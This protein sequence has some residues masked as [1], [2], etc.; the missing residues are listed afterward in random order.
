MIVLKFE[1]PVQSPLYMTHNLDYSIEYEYNQM[2]RRNSENKLNNRF[3]VMI[4]LGDIVLPKQQTVW[5]DELIERLA[6][7]GVLER[8][9]RSTLTRMTKDGW[10]DVEKIGRRNR[11]RLTDWAQGVL[12]QGDLRIFEQAVESWDGNWHLITYALPENKRVLR[13]QLVQQLTW[14]GFG[15]IARGTWLS[16][17]D[18][19]TALQQALKAP[20]T[21]SYLHFFAGDYLGNTD[22]Q[23]L[24]HQCWD[25][26]EIAHRYGEFVDAYAPILS[27]FEAGN[28]PTALKERFC[29]RVWLSY[30]FLPLLQI[31]PNLPT[32][33]LPPQWAG[34]EARRIYLALKH[35]IPLTEG[36]FAT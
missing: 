16:P 32:Q 35:Y 19:R 7:L 13:Q 24:I 9:A 29:Q 22:I 20:E 3:V 31:D 15:R 30:D 28:G 14:L 25:F 18:R 8:T 34:F 4:I 36:N 21:A 2:M 33:F 23:Q 10:F 1:L 11:L 12:R 27:Q 17:Y 5:L 26:D 6:W